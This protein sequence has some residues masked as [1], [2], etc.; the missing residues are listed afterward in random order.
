MGGKGHCAVCPIVACAKSRGYWTCAE[1]EDLDFESETPC[2][3][4][5]SHVPF[6][7]SGAMFKVVCQR[8]DL[9]NVEALKRCREIGYPSFIAELKEKARNGWRTWQVISRKR[10]F[11]E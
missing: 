2:P 1:C 4:M 11:R 9:H 7:T 3:K 10:L 5:E 6:E 8:Y